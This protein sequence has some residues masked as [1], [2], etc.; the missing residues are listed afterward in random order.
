MLQ[1][2]R[3]IGRIAAHTCCSKHIC[4]STHVCKILMHGRHDSSSRAR[5]S[6]ERPCH[7]IRLS[8]WFVRGEHMVHE[9]DHMWPSFLLMH[10]HMLSSALYICILVYPHVHTCCLQ[11]CTY[12]SHAA[13]SFLQPHHASFHHASRH[14]FIMH[15]SIGTPAAQ[16]QPRWPSKAR[17]VPW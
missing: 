1:D 5:Y 14:Y 9:S 6:S 11:L 3:P 17:P 10:A 4:C 12:S 13:A 2:G 8:T 16:P 15:H 7:M